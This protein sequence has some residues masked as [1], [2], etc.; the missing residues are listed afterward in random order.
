[1]IQNILLTLLI[2]LSFTGCYEIKNSDSLNSTT[3]SLQTADYQKTIA[4]LEGVASTPEEYFELANAYMQRSGLILSEVIQ[5]ISDS[6]KDAQS[7]FLAFVGSVKSSNETDTKSID[8]LNKATD[9]Q[10]LIIGD[11]CEEGANLTDFEKD[12][13]L[14]KGLTQTMEVANTINAMSDDI[15]QINTQ[16]DEKL[17][18][19]SCA[20]Q[21]AFNGIVDNCSVSEIGKVTFDETSTTYDRI[22]VY[23]NG[24]E[25]E[26]LLHKNE[27]THMRELVITDGYCSTETFNTREYKLTDASYYPCPVTT[28]EKEEEVTANNNLIDSLNEGTDAILAVADNYEELAQTVRDFRIEISTVGEDGKTDKTILEMDIDMQDMIEYLNEQNNLTQQDT[29]SK[30]VTSQEDTLNEQNNLTYS[31]Y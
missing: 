8:D 26:Y 15:T 3:T 20:M 25:Y 31:N 24:K 21:Y 1:M 30:Q 2:T 17:Q 13:C 22:A 19:S 23:S 4:R 10:M 5:S 12:V 29:F 7:P 9:Y 16:G 14:Y 11:R 28:D 6:S 18:A 27:I